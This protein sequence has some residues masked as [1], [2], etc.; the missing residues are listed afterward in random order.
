M[1]EAQ[2]L[3]SSRSMSRLHSTSSV[4]GVSH[5]QHRL[6]VSALA[7]DMSTVMSGKRSPEGILYSA[8]RDGLVMAWEVGVPTK[9]RKRKPQE[10]P[11]PRSRTGD[12]KVMT[13][14]DEEDDDV[15]DEEG[16]SD[17]VRLAVEAEHEDEP[18]IGDGVDK[19]LPYER[20]WMVDHEKADNMSL[21]CPFRFHSY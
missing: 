5:P 8:G 4:A 14:F 3:P 13:A 11:G 6:G 21:V 7:L 16:E 2:T 12:W 17:V 18:L 19:D 1:D 10:G 15:S 20:Q 9:P